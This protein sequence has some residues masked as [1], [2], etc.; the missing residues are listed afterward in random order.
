[1]EGRK[2]L[3]NFLSIAKGSLGEVRSQLYV[4]LDQVYI[5]KTEFEQIS[6]LIE[7][8]SRMIGGLMNYLRKT[9]IKGLKYKTR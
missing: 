1:M 7:N 6:L 3:Y 8:T 2:S 9:N 5:D 4:A